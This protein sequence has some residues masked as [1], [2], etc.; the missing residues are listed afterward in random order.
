VAYDGTLRSWSAFGIGRQA[1]E[2]WDGDIAEVIAFNTAVNEAQRIIINNYL[3]A[4][5][6]L[7]LSEFDFYTMD[8]VGN[9]DYDHDVAGIG[10]VN[11]LNQHTDARGSGIVRILNATNLDDDEFLIWGHDG[12]T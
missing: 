10:R 9:G 2:S 12:G 4:K 7:P 1:G 3:S 8:D 11:A 6:N 5:Y